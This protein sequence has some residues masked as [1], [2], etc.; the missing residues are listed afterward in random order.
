M[1]GPVSV[2]PLSQVASGS[3]QL[4]HMRPRSRGEG[5]HEIL[6]GSLPSDRR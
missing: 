5:A 2:Y 6:L 3:A 4:K 1:R